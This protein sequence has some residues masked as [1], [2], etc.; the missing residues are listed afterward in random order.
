MTFIILTL[1]LKVM[2]VCSMGCDVVTF[3]RILP[4][5]IFNAGQ[6]PTGPFV[7][8]SYIRVTSHQV[9]GHLVPQLIDFSLVSPHYLL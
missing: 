1:W 8:F 3:S 9:N 2:Q 6:R 7:L 4:A 5:L